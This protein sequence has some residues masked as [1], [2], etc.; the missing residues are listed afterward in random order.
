MEKESRLEYSD[1][2]KEWRIKLER[3]LEFINKY[4]RTPRGSG[5]KNIVWIENEKILGSWISTQ[6]QNYIKKQRI[7]KDENIRKEWM[8][9][10]EKEPRLESS[11]SNEEWRIKLERV[12]EFINKYDRTPRVSGNKN[13]IWIEDEKVIGKWLSTQRANYPKKQYIMEDENIRTEWRDAIEKEPRLRGKNY[14][15]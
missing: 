12:L 9:V 8:N 6:R 13:T 15:S 1:N 4:D 14:I 11:D 3:V 7:M 5:G 2:I 10:L